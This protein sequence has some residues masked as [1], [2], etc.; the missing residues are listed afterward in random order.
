MQKKNINSH[1]IVRKKLS[2]LLLRRRTAVWEMSYKKITLFPKAVRRFTFLYY[3]AEKSFVFCF[4]FY[5]FQQIKAEFTRITSADLRGSFFS[6]L[7]QHLSRLLQL[8]RASSFPELKKVLSMLEEDVS[9]FAQ[10]CKNVSV[11]DT[12]D[13]Y[14][15]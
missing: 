15:L 10:G 11:K 13:Q 6:G 4:Y 9:I 14:S 1:L 7:G 3:R 12:F 5:F 8:Y 2:H